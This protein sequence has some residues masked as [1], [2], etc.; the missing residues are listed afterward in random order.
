M[1]IFHT[2]YTAIRYVY[3]CTI[4]KIQSNYKGWSTFQNNTSYIH[5]DILIHVTPY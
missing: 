2:Y 4:I 5:Q 3:I 1:A